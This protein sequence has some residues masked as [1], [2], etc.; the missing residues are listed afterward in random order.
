[1]RRGGGLWYDAPEDRV[2]RR[3][4]MPS[5][6]AE[7]ACVPCRGNVPALRG[8]RVQ[9]LLRELGGGWRV[10]NEHHLEKTY[11]FEDFAEAL[12]F[13][14]E[15]G[16]IAEREGHHPEIHLGWGRVRLEIWTHAVDGLTESDFVLAAKA[17]RALET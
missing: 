3:S 7:K 1:M 5:T 14:N 11:A 2:P 17:D 16:A 15:V 13:T 10:V 6:L 4:A 9:E 8:A 12:A